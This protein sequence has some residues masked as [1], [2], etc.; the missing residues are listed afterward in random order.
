MVPAVPGYEARH[1]PCHVSSRAQRGVA[2]GKCIRVVAGSAH[3]IPRR[4]APRDDMPLLDPLLEVLTAN[5]GFG[6]RRK[7]LPVSRK[8]AKTQRAKRKR[9]EPRF[10]HPLLCVSAPLRE[11]LFLVSLQASRCQAEAVFLSLQILKVRS[12]RMFR[13]NRTSL[14]SFLRIG[15]FSTMFNQGLKV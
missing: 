11:T 15:T 14:L 9:S 3:P 8:G 4:S 5:P 7:T 12:A 1:M 13:E 10:S 2:C 6:I